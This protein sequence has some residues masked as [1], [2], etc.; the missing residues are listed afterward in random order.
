MNALYIVLA[1]F[2]FVLLESQAYRVEQDHFVE[3]KPFRKCCKDMPSLEAEVLV[4]VEA[5]VA[6]SCWSCPSPACP[7]SPEALR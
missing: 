5:Y 4:L 6:W 3:R 7:D 2:G 1:V